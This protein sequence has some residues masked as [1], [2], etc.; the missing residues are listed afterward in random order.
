MNRISL[1]IWLL[2]LTATTFA[3]PQTTT[4]TGSLKGYSASMGYKTGKL[5]VEDAVTG[6]ANSYI[7]NITPEGIFKVDFPLNINKECWISLP[8]FNGTVYFLA[9][10]KTIQ[11]FDLSAFPKI[12]SVFE[13][14]GAKV[15]NDINKVR[16]ILMDYNWYTILLD[17]YQYSPEQYKAYF[18]KIQAK[19]IAG[20][21]SVTKIVGLDKTAYNL[22]I[23]DI[24]YTIANS[25]TSYNYNMDAAY[26]VRN[27]VSPENRSAMVKPVKLE[28]GYY[29][30]LNTIQYNRIGALSSYNYNIFIK[31]LKSLDIIYD[32]AGRL[33]YT[34]EITRLKKLDTTQNDIKF[35]LKHHRQSMRNN[36]VE[37][38]KLVKAR[39]EVL[40]SLIKQNISLELE[41]MNLQDTCQNIDANKIPLTDAALV[42]LKAKLKNSYLFEPVLQLNNSVK[43]AINTSK[44]KSGYVSN[45]TPKVAVD[46]VFE[47]I[48]SKYKG[49]VIF[50]DFWATWCGPCLEGIEE[51]KAVK[52]ELK[53]QDIVFLYITNQTSPETTYKVMIPDI[54]GE[55]YK[56][57]EDEYNVISERLKINGI[58]HY[59]ILNKKGQIVN[60][61]AHGV[62]TEQLKAQLT[63]MA[64]E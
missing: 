1:L 23:D 7:I 45:E 31:R 55:H 12:S 34:D 18:L 5:I 56:I 16:P 21:D 39:P 30:F 50:I 6:L 4:Y 38:S 51:M 8:F 22:A 40:K 64:K 10:K 29:D 60:N 53:D 46:D 19:K 41:L 33:D 15:N 28:A 14:D 43:Q 47:N 57:T 59:T 27:N 62:N 9:G 3:T 42:R 11:K 48:I 2:L 35:L 63:Q 24:R 13:G 61:G 32:K 58:P 54:K 44:T 25:L 36:A 26:R 17:V 20:V 52:A 49:K 37:T